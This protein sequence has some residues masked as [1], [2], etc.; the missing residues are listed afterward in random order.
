[1]RY[2][3][4]SVDGTIMVVIKDQAVKLADVE[5]IARPYETI[6]R[7]DQGMCLGG[8]NTFVRVDY[9]DEALA[10]LTRI[11]AYVLRGLEM[12]QTATIGT[13][14]TVG[15]ADGGMFRA[16]R[17]DWGAAGKLFYGAE[18]AARQLATIMLGGC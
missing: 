17:E 16:E 12:G 8:G 18:H 4:N 5:A 3:C 7:D 11:F 6:A 15:P 2:Q 13:D 14:I 10:P 1:V 9:A